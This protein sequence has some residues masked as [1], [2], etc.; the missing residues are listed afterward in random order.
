MKGGKH[1]TRVLTFESIN[2]AILVRGQTYF[3]VAQEARQMATLFTALSRPSNLANWRSSISGSSTYPCSTT[4]KWAGVTCDSNGYITNIEIPN[5]ALSCTKFYLTP[6]SYFS[7][8]NILLFIFPSGYI[9]RL[10]SQLF[11]IFA[12]H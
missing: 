8:S 1:S 11:S 5:K 3:T 10:V 4:A 2:F 6:L 7:L 9:Q 12:S